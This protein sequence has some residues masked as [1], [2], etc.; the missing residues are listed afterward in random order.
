VATSTVAGAPS[1]DATALLLELGHI[2][3][4][5]QHNVD[6]VE[7][8]NALEGE[9]R[10][11]VFLSGSCRSGGVRVIPGHVATYPPTRER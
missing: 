9:Q 6:A 8:G 1:A 2:N 7:M 3:V 10:K 11:S 5:G 4:S